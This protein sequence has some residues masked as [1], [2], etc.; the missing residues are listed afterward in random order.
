MGLGREGTCGHSHKGE[1]GSCY[2]VDINNHAI[3][4]M[5]RAPAGQLVG[6]TDPTQ[7]AGFDGGCPRTYGRQA[8]RAYDFAVLNLAGLGEM[9]PYAHALAWAGGSAFIPKS[10]RQLLGGYR[11]RSGEGRWPGA[12][13][14]ISCRS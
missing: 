14:W 8:A 1:H 7:L 3:W 11:W 13:N 2:S 9:V 10:G 6:P 5:F 12:G 4:G